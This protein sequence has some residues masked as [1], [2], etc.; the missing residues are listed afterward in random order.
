MAMDETYRTSAM[1][2]GL[3]KKKGIGWTFHVDTICPRAN[4]KEQSKLGQKISY[5]VNEGKL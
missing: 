3:R 5:K 2:V 1:E 4:S